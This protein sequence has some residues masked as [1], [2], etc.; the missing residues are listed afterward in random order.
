MDP[1]IDESLSAEFDR[2]QNTKDVE[3]NTPPPKKANDDAPPKQENDISATE[4]RVRD[5]KG[6]FQTKD[7]NEPPA[8]T[9]KAEDEIPAADQSEQEVE[10]DQGSE[11]EPELAEEPQPLT[12][13]DRWSAEWKATFAT[14][15]RTA[16]QVLLDRESEYSKGFDQKS[17]EAASLKR[18]YEPLGQ[19]IEPRKQAWAMQGLTPE[20]AI[21]Q[22]VAISEYATSDP[23]GFLKW[24]ASQNRI[25][26]QQ[27]TGVQPQQTGTD[28][29]PSSTQNAPVATP[30][31]ASVLNRVNSLERFFTQQHQA[32]LNA[33]IESFKKAPGHE[34]F[35]DVRADM[36]ALIQAGRSADMEEAYQKA[37][38][39]NPSIRD[40]IQAEQ[41]AKDDAARKAAEAER[42]KQ[43]KLAAEKAKKAAGTQ[44]TPKASLNGGT[45]SPAT[46][47]ETLNKVYDQITGAA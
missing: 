5:E 45:P 13:P 15:P 14:L 11:A 31:I 20:Q 42:V 1:K 28:G 26:L 43:Q 33:Q 25:D 4:G 22:V 36:G 16:Q 34:H 10:P 30:E 37:I 41:R 12:P 44:I 21:S 19:L 3:D 17:Q 35:E 47:D 7:K 46:M 18:Q 24:F 23:A 27:L 29:Q 39:A 8:A 2:L 9:A 6:R 38:W 40:K 32:Q